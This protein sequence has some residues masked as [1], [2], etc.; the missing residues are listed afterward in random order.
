MEVVRLHP[1]PTTP[2]AAVTDLTVAV[3]PAAELR[4]TYELRGDLA[5]IALPEPVAPGVADGLWRHTCFEVF[6]ACGDGERYVELN[7]SPSG[8]WAAYAFAAYRQRA[9]LAAP[10]PAPA[11]SWQRDADRLLLTAAVPLAAP[12]RLGLAAVIE[13][14]AGGLSYWALC[15][16]AARPDFHHAGG[17]AL[18]LAPC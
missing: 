17:F 14:S 18:R 7:F 4:L 1:H 2:C 12:R 16:P 6:A 11:L 9:A 3:A 13:T 10:T 8:Q 15:H 5:A